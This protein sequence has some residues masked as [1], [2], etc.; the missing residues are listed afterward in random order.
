MD[1]RGD[2]AMLDRQIEQLT[3]AQ[4]LPEDEVKA[5]CEKVSFFCFCSLLEPLTF[6]FCPCR[7]SNSDGAGE[8]NFVHR[9]QRATR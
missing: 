2:L 4:Q 3:S 6:S 1:A 9:V 5:L 7:L 8:R